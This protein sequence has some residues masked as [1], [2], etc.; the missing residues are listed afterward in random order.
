T[1][2]EENKIPDVD[3]DQCAKGAVFTVKQLKSPRP[4]SKAVL[5]PTIPV[6]PKIFIQHPI[7][8]S[9]LL[10]SMRRDLLS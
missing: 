2:R 1:K 9:L 3:K 4:L 10:A 7:E 6:A 5:T 8:Q